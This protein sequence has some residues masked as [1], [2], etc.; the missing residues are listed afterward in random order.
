ML[1]EEINFERCLSIND[2]TVIKREL[3]EDELTR[4][5]S[6]TIFYPYWRRE[7]LRNEAATL[8]F[9]ALHTSIPVPNCRLYTRDGLLHL[10]MSR[11]TNG[12]LL[13]EVEQARKIAAIKAVEVQRRSNILPQLCLLRRSFI[14][15]VDD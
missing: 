13:S 8:E 9:I 7:R 15:S 4:T 1:T 6:E 14:G 10:E 2:N 3:R 5:S 11:I 12:I